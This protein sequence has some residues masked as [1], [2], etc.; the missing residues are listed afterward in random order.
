[1][2]NHNCY[3]QKLSCLL[4]LKGWGRCGDLNQEGESPGERTASERDPASYAQPDFIAFPFSSLPPGFP[5]VRLNRKPE[6]EGALLMESP[7]VSLLGR[8]QGGE[9]RGHI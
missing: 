8:K 3:S 5:L 6:E 9:G 4:D 2:G 7:Q 1:M